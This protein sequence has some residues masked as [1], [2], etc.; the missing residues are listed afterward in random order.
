MTKSPGPAVLAACLAAGCAVTTPKPVTPSLA[1]P[2]GWQGAG[3]TAQGEGSSSP[4]DLSRWWQRLGDP[5]LSDLVARALAD[6]PD[7][8]TARARVREARARR[9]LT[10]KGYLPDLTASVSVSASRTSGGTGADHDSAGFDASWEPDIFGATRHAV[11]AAQ[12]ELQATEASQH[13]TQ[14]TLV[15]ELALAYVDLRALQARLS[16]ARDNLDRQTE[17]L[18]LTSWRAQAGLTSDLDVEQAR[19]NVGQ[20]RAQIPTLE[21]GQAEAEHR[22]AVLIGEPP[23]A[24]HERLATPGPIPTAPA[25]L[26]I[27]IPADTLRQRPDVQAAERRLAAETARLG[28]ARAALFPSLRLSGSIGIDALSL[29]GLTSAETVVRSLLGGLTAPIFDRGKIRRQIEIQ[30]AVQEQA[31]AT[32]ESTVLTALQDV[33]DAL[34]SLASAERRQQALTTATQAARAAAELARK[35]YEAGLIGY[36]TVL[37][38]ERSLL[39][40]EDSLKSAEADGTTAL[41][42]LFKALGGGWESAPTVARGAH[43]EGEES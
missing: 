25:R 22:L 33:E 28:Q 16:I 31:L 43:S 29:G 5:A 30:D 8:R 11:S 13:D 27:G 40:V 24:L 21:A 36:Q 26:S 19:T 35:Q 2:Q 41:I 12:A 17:T 18:E 23:A 39:A 38:T 42:R 10:G 1:I 37:D 9:G 4:E 3:Q 15:A 34:A 6:N 14:V 20:T 7:L 32:Y